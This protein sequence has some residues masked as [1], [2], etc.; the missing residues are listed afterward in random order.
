[1]PEMAKIDLPFLNVQCDRT[2][3]MNLLVFRRMGR[4][5]RLPAL[6]DPE[7]MLR[8]NELLAAT[9]PTSAAPETGVLPGSFGALVADYSA[10][11]EFKNTKPNTQR[12]Y[13]LVLEPLAQL[14]RDKPVA[15]LERRH[16]KAWRD[17]RSETPGMANM[18]VKVVR[19][20]MT[21]AVDNEYR[22]DNPVRRLELLELGDTGRGVMTNARSSKAAGRRAVCSGELMPSRSSRGSAAATSP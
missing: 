3:R 4:R 21:Y 17:A 15:L 18:V 8:Y 7:F 13:R 12:M 6:D 19:S 22:R 16:V 20:L 14:H 5:W 1:M 11:P 2:G 9:E 10:S